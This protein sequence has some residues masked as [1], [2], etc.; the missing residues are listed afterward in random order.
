MRPL[1]LQ[2][3]EHL[4]Q[5]RSSAQFSQIETGPVRIFLVF[6]A[7]YILSQFYRSFLAV[8]APELATEIGLTP[9]DLGTMSAIWFAAF[10]VAQFPVGWALDRFG[11]RRTL[12]LIMTAAALGALVFA[13]STTTATCYIAMALIGLGCSPIYMGALYVFGR[14]FPPD[15]FALLCS[16]LLGVGSSGNL[17]AATPLAYAADR[18]GWRATFVAMSVITLAA[19]LLTLVMV[20][21]PPRLASPNGGKPEGFISGLR[22]I[23]AIRAL[24]L[25]LPMVT[26]SYA[27]LAAERGLWA[28]PYFAEVHGLAPVARGNAVLVFAIAMSLGALLYGPLDIVIKARKWVIVVGSLMSVAALTTLALWPQPTVPL[29]TTLL[30][31]LGLTGATYGLLMAHGRTFLPDHLLGRGITVLNFLF[32][33]GGVLMQLLSGAIA[34]TLRRQ[35]ATSADVYAAVHLCFA[36]ALLIVTVIYA[37]AREKRA[38]TAAR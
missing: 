24:W 20:Q 29:A 11:P 10:A 37:G 35:G 8:I 13:A 5:V 22:S 33:G 12:P 6:L 9:S 17:L 21:D 36:V 27:V 7:S 34:E 16:W 18:F 14:T 15:R 2:L 30:A 23:L 19:M 1:G 3:T 25:I 38:T 28:G 32:I 31:I 26:V 4:L